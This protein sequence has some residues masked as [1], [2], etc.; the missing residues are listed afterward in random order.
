MVCE[1]DRGRVAVWG[2]PAT[3]PNVNAVQR[4]NTPFR[5]RASTTSRPNQNFQDHDRW[6]PDHAVIEIARIDERDA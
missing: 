1:T 2:K 4:A 3:R 6:I 5:L